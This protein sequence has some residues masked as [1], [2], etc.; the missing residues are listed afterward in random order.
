[1][2]ETAAILRN[3]RHSL[4]FILLFVRWINPEHNYARRAGALFELRRRRPSAWLLPGL[5]AMVL[6]GERRGVRFSV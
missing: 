2:F 1:M 6:K 5:D 3:A 4:V